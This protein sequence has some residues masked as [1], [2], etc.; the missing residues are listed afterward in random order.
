LEQ[1]EGEGGSGP[2]RWP[3]KESIPNL[4]VVVGAEVQ[5]QDHQKIGI[6]AEVR[7]DYFK[8]KTS[9]WQRD[10]WLRGDIIRSAVPGQ[11]A[12]LK[13]NKAGLTEEHKI[14]DVPP[15]D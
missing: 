2:Q 11:V 12:I 14:V 15:R 5:T 13:V 1:N 3:D 9:W 6:V 4:K 7:G 10:F 8:I